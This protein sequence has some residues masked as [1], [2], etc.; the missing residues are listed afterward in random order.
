MGS[1]WKVSRAD[2]RGK[3]RRDGREF[4]GNPPVGTLMP[5]LEVDELLRRGRLIYRCRGKVLTNRPRILKNPEHASGESLMILRVDVR[6][7]R[8]EEEEL[9]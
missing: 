2:V 9:V 4:L 3:C 7:G 8:E 1:D 5:P 6:I